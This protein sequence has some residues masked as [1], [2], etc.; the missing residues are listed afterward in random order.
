MQQLQTLAKKHLGK[1]PLPRP[2]KRQP[3][4][5][6]LSSGCTSATKSAGQDWERRMAESDNEDDEDNVKPGAE[7]DNPS[8]LAGR[9]AA[10]PAEK[11]TND[12]V[13][14]P[15][16]SIKREDGDTA[17]MRDGN[18]N[19]HTMKVTTTAV[20]PSTV[21][22]PSIEQ[23]SNA[24]AT[25]E[26]PIDGQPTKA[27]RDRRRAD[28]NA[29]TYP[30]I[31]EPEPL[32]I[33]ISDD[34]ADGDIN[35]HRPA[36]VSSIKRHSIVTDPTALTPTTTKQPTKKSSGRATNTENIRRLAEVE[37]MSTSTQ[38]ARHRKTGSGNKRCKI[39]AGQ[40][41]SETKVFIDLTGDGEQ[42]RNDQ[43]SVR[44]Q[45][46]I[47]PHTTASRPQTVYW[48]TTTQ[49]QMYVPNQQDT[50][51]NTC[52]PYPFSPRHLQVNPSMRK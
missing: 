23:P 9:P 21:A 17:D 12:H 47:Q 10:D 44:R 36:R 35:N 27:L 3:H 45:I 11:P 15:A 50:N 29:F 46:Q 18:T 2:K 37:K 20:G 32:P 24:S 43:L 52:V 34:D 48:T 38:L 40:S 7:A 1:A 5:R 41:V 31:P 14:H 28:L 13:I 26:Q 42:P 49:T 33:I 22:Q 6:A 19:F 39:D 30:A 8:V 16:Q 25:D 4:K 51:H